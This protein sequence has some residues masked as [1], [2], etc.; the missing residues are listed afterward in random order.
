MKPLAL[1]ALALL[2]PVAAQPQ[3]G[4][5]TEALE[6]ALAAGYKAGFTCSATFNAGQTLREI[7]LNELSGIYPDYRETYEALPAAQIDFNRKIVTVS[8]GEGMP[9]RM[10]VWRKG[11]GCTQL[12]IGAGEEAIEYLPAFTEWP[13]AP[14]EE[15]DRVEL[16]PGILRDPISLSSFGTFDAAVDFAFDGATYGEGTK[17]SAVLIVHKGEIL[18]ERYARG[19]NATTPQR[20]WSVAKSIAATIIGA[21][22]WQGVTDIDH[23]IVIDAWSS[24]ADPRHKIT[25]RNLL[26]MASGLDSGESGSRT[27]RVYFGG[28]RVIDAA[29]TAVL[30]APPGTRFKYANNDTLIALRSIREKIGDD[31]A[32]L[33]FPYEQ[34]LWKIGAY[35]TTLETDWNG[36][37]IGSSQV[38]TTARDL[39]RIGL[40]YLNHGMWGD[41]RLLPQDW[42]EFVTTPAPAQPEGDSFGYGA[43]FWLF[44]H[45]GVPDD[46]FAAMGHRGQYLVIIPSRDLIIVRR[47]YDNS[48]GTRFA[49]DRFTADI[50]AA[51]NAANKAREREEMRLLM[52]DAALEAD[53]DAD[54]LRIEGAAEGATGE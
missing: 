24:G 50:V 10:A 21:A 8:Y 46:A 5:Q 52:G 17:T 14:A 54:I 25:L 40:L 15:L 28:A 37:F 26:N 11:L 6:K 12:P 9:P 53:P 39:A 19:I 13:D 1:A 27:D 44:D 31:G 23:P 49:I 2:L 32:Y 30:E 51:L 16:M 29:T 34:L 48:G 38:W 41:E 18:Q 42:V 36:D 4:G 43:Q 45:D 47:G 22:E 7:E 35:R 3:E 20:T 33:R